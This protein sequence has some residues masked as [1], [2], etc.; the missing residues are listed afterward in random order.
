M[1]IG[2]S[3][4]PGQMFARLRRRLDR[5][6]ACG[7]Q[8]TRVLRGPNLVE[9]ARQPREAGETTGPRGKS[10]HRRARWLVTPTRGNPR[11]SATETH[12]LREGSQLNPRRQG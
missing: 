2:S 9:L 6:E 10:G 5:G 3:M 4:R 12:R 1:T 7:D 11:E 8:W